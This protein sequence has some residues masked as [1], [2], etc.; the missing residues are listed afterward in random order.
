MLS[1]VGSI[2][3]H[4]RARRAPGWRR[5]RT[6]ARPPRRSLPRSRDRSG[7]TA[8]SRR[9]RRRSR[10]E[11]EAEARED[12]RDRVVGEIAT[13]RRRATRARR[14][15][16]GSRRGSAPCDVG[17]AARRGRRRSRGSVASRARRRAR[18]RRNRRRARSDS[19]RRSR[20]RA[21]AILPWIT[22]GF[23]NAPSRNTRRR[24]VADAA[25]ARRP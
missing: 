5:S 15:R 14:T 20:S 4:V 19:R 17:R 22:A 9:N 23:Q 12:R 6:G 16:T 7:T 3:L 10:V 8:A 13:P 18:S 11:R 21:G 1:G 24:V 2:V 25:S